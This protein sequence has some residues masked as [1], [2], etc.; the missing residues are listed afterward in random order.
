MTKIV[1]LEIP[2]DYF[3]AIAEFKDD[4]QHAKGK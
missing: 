2:D 4:L 3:D 1:Q